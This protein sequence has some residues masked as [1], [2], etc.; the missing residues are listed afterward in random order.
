MN[1]RVSVTTIEQAPSLNSAGQY[2]MVDT[3]RTGE[4]V[5]L[6]ILPVDDSTDEFFFST[7]QNLTSRKC[8]NDTNIEFIGY[9]PSRIMDIKYLKPKL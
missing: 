2:Q 8:A 9:L 4:I 5:V 1:T 7:I 6:T 3:L